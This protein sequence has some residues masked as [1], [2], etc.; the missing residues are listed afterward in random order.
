MRYKSFFWA[1]LA[2][3][4][5]ALHSCAPDPI[6]SYPPEYKTPLLFTLDKPET[7]T[8]EN[9]DKV[10]TVD[11][12][13]AGDSVTVFLPTTYTGA[14]LYRATYK[15][16]SDSELLPSE[17]IIKSDPCNTSALPPKRTFVA[18]SEPG[19]YVVYFRAIYECSGAT[20]SG[21]TS[22]GYPT[23]SGIHGYEDKSSVYGVL[24]V[25]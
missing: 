16:T 11:C 22:L 18:P 15:W 3:I 17:I 21:A 9:Q 6:Y 25:E 5:L 14:Y 19:R 10:K 8:W 20:E 1:T 13:N 24:Y 23:I 7:V 12:C 4:G 2:M